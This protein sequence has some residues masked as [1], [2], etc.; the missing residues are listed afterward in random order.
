VGD[1]PVALPQGWRPTP[2]GLKLGHLAVEE[3]VAAGEQLDQ[4]PVH[5]GQLPD[6]ALAGLAPGQPEAK[7][8][9]LGGEL[10]CV[11]GL[12]GGGEL[13][14][15]PRV[16]GQI[17]APAEGQVEDEGVAVSCGSGGRP[18]SAATSLVGRLVW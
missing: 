7:P 17:P 2:P 9:Q 16:D 6:A 5:P 14:D 3:A 4:A 12:G 15:R 8:L 11:D 13:V 18:G 1:Q 10:A